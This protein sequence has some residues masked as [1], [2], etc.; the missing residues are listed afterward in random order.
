MDEKLVALPIAHP[1]NGIHCSRC[2]AK[3]SSKEVAGDF[4]PPSDAICADCEYQSI[5]LCAV[6]HFEWGKISN[7]PTYV[8]K[9]CLAKPIL[10]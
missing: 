5:E 1:A 7:N 4:A 3:V 2:G 9:A 10:R 6:C 8:C